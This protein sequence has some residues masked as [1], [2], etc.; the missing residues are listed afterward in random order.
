MSCTLT[1][2]RQEVCKESIG[3]LAGAYFINYTTG[4]F[5]KKTEVVKLPLYLQV[6]QF[7]TMN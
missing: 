2:G 7:T 3:G 6:A 5:T 1:Q 4:S